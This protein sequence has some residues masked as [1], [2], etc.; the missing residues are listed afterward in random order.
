MNSFF[1]S[2]VPHWRMVGPTRVS[3]K[4]SPRIGAPARA[5]SSD[6]TTP[7]MVV[8]PLPPYS[9]GQV[10]QIQP[11]SKRVAVHCSS[12]APRSSSVIE[13]SS[14]NQPDGRL[15]SSHS[16]ISTRNSSASGG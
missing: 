3:P 13:K 14:S 7:C 15:F 9:V 4:K 1:C 6:S 5:N 8:R 10:A 11:P 2:S 12:Q 16:R